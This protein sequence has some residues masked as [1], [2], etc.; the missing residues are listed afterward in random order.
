[1][2]GTTVP[3]SQVYSRL[4]VVV[5]HHGPVFGYLVCQQDLQCS[6]KLVGCCLVEQP[7]R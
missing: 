6:I 5:E 4:H 2:G 3:I 7:T 1:M